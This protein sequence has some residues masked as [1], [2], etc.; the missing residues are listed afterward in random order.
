[1]NPFISS[2]VSI[3]LKEHSGALEEEDPL[4][5]LWYRMGHALEGIVRALM[6]LPGKFKNNQANWD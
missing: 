2:I 4:T 6:K 3:H 1:M 5:A